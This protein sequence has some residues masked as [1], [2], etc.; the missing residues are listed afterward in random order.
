MWP[1]RWAADSLSWHNSYYQHLEDLLLVTMTMASTLTATLSSLHCQNYLYDASMVVA[2]NGEEDPLMILDVQ[3]EDRDG[4][5]AEDDVEEDHHHHHHHEGIHHYN[6]QEEDRDGKNVEDDEDDT[7]RVEVVVAY[8]SYRN[9]E[10]NEG[11]VF[12][13]NVV[14]HHEHRAFDVVVDSFALDSYYAYHPYPCP[15]PYYYLDWDSF[16][17]FVASTFHYCHCHLEETNVVV[18]VVA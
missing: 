11:M 12:E 8:S 7:V 2:S 15:C 5:N 1:Y 14:D 4:M 18:A 6:V 16:D 13:K 17:A 9:D 10:K 3:E